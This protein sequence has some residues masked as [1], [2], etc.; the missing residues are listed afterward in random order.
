[1]HPPF[2][3]VPFR[4]MAF[5]AV[6]PT[7]VTQ[8]GSAQNAPAVTGKGVTLTDNGTTV[9]IEMNGQLFTEYH[10][11]EFSFPVFFPVIGPG[12]APMTR[13]YPFK[14][15]P[16]E[17]HDHPHHRS[18]WFTHSRINEVNFWAV[19]P[20]KDKKP[21]ETRHDGFLAM[22]SGPTMGL[23]RCKNRYV[24]P[25]TDKVICTDERTYRFYA[26][27]AQDDS[28]QMDY[29]V[30]IHASEGEVVFGD[31]KDGG[32]AIR[33]AVTMQN[34]RQT[35]DKK[36]PSIPAAG[37]LV[38]SEGQRDGDTWGKRARWV[39]IQGPVDGKPVGVAMFDHPGNPRHPTWWHARTYGLCAA[40]SW[41]Q[42][43]FEGKP[44]VNL[45]NQTIPRGESMTLRYRLYFHSGDEK[46]AR[47]EEEYGNY[48]RES[49]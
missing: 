2:R 38:N 14:E 41:G 5:L 10:Y 12:G 45:G 25:N 34:T 44:D 39:D 32:M 30:T 3:P 31:Q 26:P 29:E 42:H 17:D 16:E 21:G 36:A 27:N 19:N 4:L 8:P 6:L 47:V 40:N 24:D 1:M 13:N 18:L 23:L 11:K 49:R 48:A 20:I 28:R 35:K 46:S 15:L 7:L 22:E 33:V 37:H 9:R 43:S